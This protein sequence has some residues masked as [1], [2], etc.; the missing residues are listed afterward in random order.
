LI[1]FFTTKGVGKGTGQ[2]LTIAHSVVVGKHGGASL[3]EQKSIEAARSLCA[4][5]SSQSQ[6]RPQDKVNEY[7]CQQGA[8]H[9]AKSLLV[10]Y[11][12]LG[13]R[14]G[15]RGKNLSAAFPSIFRRPSLSSSM[16]M[17]SLLRVWCHGSTRRRNCPSA[18]PAT[19]NRPGQR[20]VFVS[21]T[22]IPVFP[23]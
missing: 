23:R 17:P 4:C 7:F 21:G 18:L 5:L 2:G 3:L 12:F 9:L 10:W 13:G 15:R 6:K 20:S 16:L 14:T 19:G 8:I 11:R 22:M 1:H